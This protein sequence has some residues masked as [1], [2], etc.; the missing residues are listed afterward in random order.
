MKREE[1]IAELLRIA[2]K[3]NIKI[4]EDRLLKRGGYCRVLMNK[5][6]IMDRDINNKEKMELL[7]DALKNNNLE[8]IY[9][10]PKIRELCSGED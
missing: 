9:I 8:D 10:T 7:I 2:E 1:I 6:L 5:Y 4:I 3:L